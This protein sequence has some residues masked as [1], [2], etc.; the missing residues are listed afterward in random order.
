[1][2]WFY[3][4]GQEKGDENLKMFDFSHV[5]SLIFTATDVMY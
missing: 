4:F 3:C 5:Q 1:M 2:L